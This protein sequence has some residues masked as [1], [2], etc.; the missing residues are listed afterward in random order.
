MKTSHFVLPLARA[1]SILFF[2]FHNWQGGAAWPRS[3]GSGP[4][5]TSLRSVRA[6]SA[7]HS[8]QRLH[9][10][11]SWQERTKREGLSSRTGRALSSRTGEFT[12]GGVTAAGIVVLAATLPPLRIERLHP[13]RGG[14]EIRGSHFRSCRAGSR[15]LNPHSRSASAS[16]RRAGSGAAA[17]AAMKPSPH[18]PEI[19]KKPKGTLGLLPATNP[20]RTQRRLCLRGVTLCRWK[21]DWDFLSLAQ[22]WSPRTTHS[23]SRPTSRRERCV[24]RFAPRIPQILLLLC[25]D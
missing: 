11:L 23:T 13:W 9:A 15:K 14:P 16:R 22:I 1:S 20:L 7:V 3:S 17:A 24:P 2:T 4:D 18:F 25:L 8:I 21:N 10:W 19:G 5:V 12:C 6:A